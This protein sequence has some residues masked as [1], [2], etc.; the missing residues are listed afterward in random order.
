MGHHISTICFVS[1]LSGLISACEALEGMR[2]EA[3][4]AGATIQ[5]EALP[6][7]LRGRIV[8]RGEFRAPADPAVAANEGRHHAEANKSDRSLLVEKTG[9][10]ANATIEVVVPGAEPAI[11]SEPLTLVRVDENFEPRVL[12]VPAGAEVSFG[13]ADECCNACF[14]LHAVKN[15]AVNRSV[16]PR[17]SFSAVFPLAETIAITDDVH[18]W[19]KAFLRVTNTR[20]AAVTGADGSFSFEGLPPGTYEVRIWH[21][22]MVLKR[23]RITLEPGQKADL[24]IELR[25]PG[26]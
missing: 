10:L 13:N 15:P 16:A 21:E 14:N 8:Y 9:G 3:R 17:T 4:E 24:E 5:T 23:D 22:R 19:S 7:T 2:P 12:L 11:P 18:P 20:F 6:A 1:L 25:R 26:E